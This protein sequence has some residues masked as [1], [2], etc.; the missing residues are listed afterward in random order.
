MHDLICQW[1]STE[2]YK[3]RL[4]CHESVAA[5][6]LTDLDGVQETNETSVPMVFVDTAGLQFEEQISDEG[7][8]YN[9]LEAEVVLQ[10]ASS[11][12]EAGVCVCV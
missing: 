11:I 2:F 9:D 5:R 6:L 4:Q 1:S 8:K 12:A 10:Y 3:G 7:S